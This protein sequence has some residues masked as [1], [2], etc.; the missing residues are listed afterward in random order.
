MTRKKKYDWNKIQ[1]EYDSGLTLRGLQERYGISYATFSKAKSR[2]DFI[3]RNISEALKLK[4]ANGYAPKHTEE[5]KKKISKHRKDYLVRNPDKVP[6]LLN[7][8]SKG[9][10]YPE[11]YF[12]NLFEAENIDLKYH[13]QVGIYQLDFYNLKSKIDVEIDGEQHYRDPRIIESDKRRTL[14][15]ESLGWKIIR[16]RWAD[17][18]KFTMDQK[19]EIVERI[20]ESI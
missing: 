16:I 2:G 11:I 15:L 3:P 13:L 12:K 5:T 4:Y 18:Q 10:S 1:L 14:L 6:Y 20:R 9:E 7:H 17:Y 8:Y 19:K